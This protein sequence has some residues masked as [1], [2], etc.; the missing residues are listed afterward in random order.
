MHHSRI[1]LFAAVVA[2]IVVLLAIGTHFL[3]PPYLENR[4]E[5][6]LEEHGG[7]ADVN[8]SAV[9]AIRLLTGHGDR[10]EVDGSGLEV[11]S[12]DP[13]EDAFD[14]L[15]KFDEVDIDLTDVEA[16]PF[17]VDHF[18]LE[19]LGDGRYRIETDA[20]ATI[21]DLG[22]VA[23]EQFGP[24]G[25]VI[26]SIVGGS[27]PFSGAPVPIHLDGELEASDGKVTMVS[28]DADV[29]NLPAGPAAR[30]VTSAIL[31]DL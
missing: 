2:G 29:A 27:A 23:G 21:Q 15:N 9:P 3:L 1:R 6:R 7:R 8:L 31:S 13:D 5:E 17:Q 22:R 4:V 11:D 19:G 24:L 26:G 18:Q 28:G 14:Q 10:L 25:G 30:L 16:D 12:D 20:T